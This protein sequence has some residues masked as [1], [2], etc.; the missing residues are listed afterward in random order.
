MGRRFGRTRAASPT[1]R[2]EN[3]YGGDGFWAFADPTDPDVVYAE[4]QGGYIGRVDRR[5]RA[6]RDIQPKAGYRR[7]AAL[8]LEHADP[9]CRPNAEG[10]DLHRRAVPLPLAR[11]R[12]DAGS[13]SRPTSRPTIPEKQKQEQS[14]GVTV[15]NS[16]AE[17]HTTIYSISESPKDAQR[18]LGRAPTTATCS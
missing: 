11:P 14:G 6:A 2:W 18:D 12:R 10:H 7:E 1:R 13:A 3:L 5:T 8:Q 9:R 15:D 4:S 17:M 16:S